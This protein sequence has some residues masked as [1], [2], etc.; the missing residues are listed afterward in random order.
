MEINYVLDLII[1]TGSNTGIQDI[2]PNLGNSE[3]IV[4][5]LME[6]FL[7]KDNWYTS[8]ISANY[9]HINKTNT[10]GTIRKKHREMQNLNKQKKIAE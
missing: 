6:P 4:G 2:D 1:Y 7:Y 8:P 5:T 9:L 3:D 10:C